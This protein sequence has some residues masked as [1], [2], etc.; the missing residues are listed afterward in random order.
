M[1]A[2]LGRAEAART[3]DREVLSSLIDMLRQHIQ[4]E[5]QA[6]VPP[7]NPLGQTD[8]GAPFISTPVIG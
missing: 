1:N 5:T 6:M 8:E 4:T 2:S 3:E 7:D